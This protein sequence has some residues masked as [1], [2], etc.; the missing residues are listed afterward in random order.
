MKKGYKVFGLVRQMKHDSLKYINKLYKNKDIVLIKGDLH[1]LG[2]IK[3]A[4]K[5]AKPDEIYNL[6]AQSDVSISFIQPEETFEVNYHG[7]GRLVNEAIKI[8]PKIKIYQASTSEMF[9]KIK[10]PQ[11]ENSPFHPFSPYGQ[12]KLKAHEDYVVG[13]REKRSIFICSGI[14][15][16]HESPRRGKNY[17]TRKITTSLVKIKLGLQDYFELGN[18]DSKRDW[19]FASDYVEVMWEMLRQKNPQDFVIATGQSHTVRDFV[20]EA[21]KV[22]GMKITW[23]GKGLKEVVK[24]ENGKVILQIN[25]KYYRPADTNYL[26]GDSKKAKRI[27]GWRLKHSF[28]DLVKIM[29]ESDLKEIKESISK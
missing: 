24:D 5:I 1:N 14:L 25:K 2:S 21:V 20:N 11:N 7:F 3:K 17:V 13:Y 22:L 27:L 9:G 8:N 23:H 6:A 26:I 28:R 10:P 18:L 12:S 4:L 29:T 19:G 16:N 15:F